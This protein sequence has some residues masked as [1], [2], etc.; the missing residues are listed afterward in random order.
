MGGDY[1]RNLPLSISLSA[2]YL[3]DGF[4]T[5]FGRALMTGS[6]DLAVGTFL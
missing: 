6:H 3:L 2:R 4:L 5:V 1:D